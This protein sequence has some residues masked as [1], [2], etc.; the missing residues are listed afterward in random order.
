[1]KN[2]ITRDRVKNFA[3]SINM[4]IKVI[5]DIRC[6]EYSFKKHPERPLRILK[7]IERLKNQ[8]E[9]AIEWGEPEIINDDMILRV[10][11]I[12]LIK[13]VK[14][15]N[16]NFDLDTPAYPNIYEYAV[17]AVGGAIAS[18][19]CIFNNQIGFSLMRPPGHHATRYRAM[20]FCYFNNIAIAVK[21]LIDDFHLKVAIYDFDLHH[22]NGT[23]E[24]F[25]N[26]KNVA[27]Y[28]VHEFPHYPGTGG[29]NIGNNCFNYTI[30]PHAPR[31]VYLDKLSVSLNDLQKY[32]PDVIAV[33]AGF[34]GFKK[35]PL[36]TEALEVEDYYWLGRQL[37]M[38]GKKIFCVLEGGYSKELPELI[39]AFL[40]GLS[41]EN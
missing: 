33:S 26:Q 34:D 2:L 20:G 36:G 29:F 11:S 30:P 41:D 27:F 23:E 37:K 24:I 1:V 6:A 25:L 5:T 17:R 7:T 10:H 39:L 15:P 12:D 14:N 31:Q 16:G 19:K 28:S 3:V 13:Q 21:M 35:D 18:A 38:T 8:N 22:G 4:P 40:K 9:V 32:D